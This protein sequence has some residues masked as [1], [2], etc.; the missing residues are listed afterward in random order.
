[1]TRYQLEVAE[2][3]RRHRFVIRTFSFVGA[4]TLIV[5]TLWSAG[6]P[7]SEWWVRMQAW[8]SPQRQPA[9]DVAALIQSKD[10]TSPSTPM[11]APP[12]KP[13]IL[14]G[15]DSSLSTS[16]QPLF[17]VATSPG[18]NKSEGTAQIGTNP[19][20]PQTYVS[21][22]LLANGTRLAEIHRDHVILTRGD[23][24]ARLEIYRRNALA[25]STS[26]ALLLVGGESQPHVPVT[27]TTEVL[28]SYLRPSPVYDGE[29]MRG[30]Q[31]YAGPK[32]GVFS[33]LGLE[34]GDVITAIDDAPLT[35]PQQALELLAQLTHGSAIVATVERKNVRKRVVLEGSL[36]REDQEQAANATAQSAP[37]MMMP[38][39]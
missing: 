13:E 17:L 38:Q 20:N 15:T 22:A 23:S 30:Y 18:R 14:P 11:V 16:P 10:S 24:A 3:D 6:L 19:E 21:G 39:T 4:A 35:D 9:N 28:T 27:M 33:R 8:L 7:P 26:N 12:S 5:A 25:A 32:A 34:A 37:P 31:V 29:V 1:M 2:M 36:I